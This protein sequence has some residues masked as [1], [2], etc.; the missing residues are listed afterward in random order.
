MIYVYLVITTVI[1]ATCIVCVVFRENQVDIF[2]TNDIA[3]Y[4]NACLQKPI[5][6]RNCIYYCLYAVVVNYFCIFYTVP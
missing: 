3:F 2:T 6:Y 1:Y 4:N 5:S